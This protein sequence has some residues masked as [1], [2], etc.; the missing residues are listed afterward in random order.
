MLTLHPLFQIFGW[1]WGAT[2]RNAVLAPQEAEEL[3]RHL[4]ATCE[5]AL[6]HF[7][8][9]FEASLSIFRVF[10]ECNWS[11]VLHA[12]SAASAQPPEARPSPPSS[13]TPSS[14]PLPA[15]PRTSG[16]GEL[17][18]WRSGVIKGYFIEGYF[19]VVYAVMGIGLC[20]LVTTIVVE[21]NKV[22]TLNPKP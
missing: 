10:I 9:F 6:P 5:A 11:D 13:F 20:N 1:P 8:C 17:F 7:N 15:Q 18:D 12:S 4:G 3:E 19:I 16:P 21:F 22:Q 14:L 2:G